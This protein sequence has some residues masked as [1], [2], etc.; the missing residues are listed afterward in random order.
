MKHHGIILTPE[1]VRAKIEGRKTQHRIVMKKQPMMGWEID[2]ENPTKEPINAGGYPITCPF[3]IGDHIYYR[4]TW[5]HTSLKDTPYVELYIYKADNKHVWLDE[6]GE[7]TD[8]QYYRSPVTMPKEAARIW[9]EVTGRRVERLG[10]ISDESAIAE[11]I[12]HQELFPGTSVLLWRYNSQSD[13]YSRPRNCYK[14]YYELKYGPG[15]W[16]RDKD[17]WCWVIETKNLSLTGKA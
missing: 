14:E 7:P 17:K 13:W 2:P 15:S 10:D 5:A 9:D 3:Q 12:M 1:Q 8:K 16:E 6:E 11:G 4:E